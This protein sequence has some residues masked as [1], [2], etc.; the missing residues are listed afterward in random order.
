LEKVAQSN[1]FTGKT[2]FLQLKNVPDHLH[3]HTAKFKDDGM[4]DVLIIQ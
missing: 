1:E 3:N 2:L 4:N